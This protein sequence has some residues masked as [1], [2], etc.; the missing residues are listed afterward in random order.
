MNGI[1]PDG[2]LFDGSP[3]WD[4]AFAAWGD[5]AAKP[6][7]DAPGTTIQELV[8]GSADA[9]VLGRPE[10]PLSHKFIRK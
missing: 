1:G 8:A 3:G 2:P 4:I 5:L 7:P 10:G 6:P 9:E